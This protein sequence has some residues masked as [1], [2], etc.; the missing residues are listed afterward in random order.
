MTDK[1]SHLPRPIADRYRAWE[2]YAIERCRNDPKVKAAGL[3]YI[4]M[5]PL[6]NCLCV[7]QRRPKAEMKADLVIIDSSAW[8]GR[9]GP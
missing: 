6:P 9:V 5:C 7:K 3:C 8:T 4:C 2:A 1:F